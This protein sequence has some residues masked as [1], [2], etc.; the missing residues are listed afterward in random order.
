VISAGAIPK[1]RRHCRRAHDF[2]LCVPSHRAK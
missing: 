1:D 2:L